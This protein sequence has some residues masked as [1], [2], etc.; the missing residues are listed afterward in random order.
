MVEQ[1]TLV[2]EEDSSSDD[3][4]GLHNAPPY[5]L[6]LGELHPLPPTR[7][8]PPPVFCD[9]LDVH[10]YNDGSAYAGDWRQGL[11]SGFGVYNSADGCQYLGVRAAAAAGAAAAG[12]AV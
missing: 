7:A 5:F 8:A 1:Q 2:E 12:T 6:P 9:G 10:V 4:D 3:E 11:R